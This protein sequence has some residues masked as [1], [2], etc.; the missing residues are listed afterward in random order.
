MGG[1]VNKGSVPV[2]GSDTAAGGEVAAE[3]M[4]ALALYN[5]RRLV[6][7]KGSRKESNRCRKVCRREIRY[8]TRQKQT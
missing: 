8:D 6:K 7:V 1:R 2:V 4:A 3:D 5:K